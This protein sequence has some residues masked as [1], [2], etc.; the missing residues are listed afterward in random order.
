[1]ATLEG[2]IAA[3]RFG[4]GAR[5]GEIEAASADPRGWLLAQLEAPAGGPAAQSLLSSAE[6]YEQVGLFVEGRRGMRANAG[7]VGD[8][9]VREALAELPNLRDLLVAE[10]AARTTFAAATPAGFHERLVRFWSNHFTVAATKLPMVA[11]SGPF[12]REAIRPNVTG[13]FADLLLAV[14]THPGMLVYLDNHFSVGPQST[15]GRRR[16]RGLNE[17]LAREILELHTLGVDGGYGQ[18]DVEEL[19]RAIT[20]WSLGN[21]F[22]GGRG[23]RGEFV[24][25]PRIHEPGAR[26]VLGKRYPESGFEQ[27]EAILRDLAR[28]PA[29]AR[30]IATK[31]ARHFVADDPPADAVAA[32][33]TVFLETDGDLKALARA[34]VAL[35]AAWAPEQRKFKTHDEYFVSAL[36][37][38]GAPDLEPMA[39]AGTYAALGQRPFSAPSPAGW[40]D[41]ADAWIGPDAVMKRLEWAEEVGRRAPSGR[42]LGVLDLALGDLVTE[43]TRRA[44]ASAASPSQ[45][46]TLALMAPEFQR[47]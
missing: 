38:L 9:V 43:D 13:S 7:D 37:A 29:T 10:I 24:F 5:P 16:D 47:R 11:L 2:A 27:G 22:F 46:L 40:P 28:H 19:A 14:E 1:M 31:L 8:D 44:V 23:R 45:G 42:P 32:L 18:G 20:G 35:E 30:H 15:A 34:V 36:R 41:E 3:T 17:N 4:L 39:L 21:R 26:T 12:E 33:E 6:A 25:E